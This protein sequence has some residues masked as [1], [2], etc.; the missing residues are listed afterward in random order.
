MV[1]KYSGSFMRVNG[2][3][4]KDVLLTQWIGLAIVTAGALLAIQS[5]PRKT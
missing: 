5:P 3:I 1:E 2:E 4:A